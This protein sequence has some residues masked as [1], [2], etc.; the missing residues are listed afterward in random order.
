MTKTSMNDELMEQAVYGGAILGGGGGGWIKDGLQKGKLALEIGEVSLTTID[1]LDVK[2]HVACVALVG[3]P[4]AKNQYVNAKQLYSTVNLLQRNYHSSISALMTNENG[5]STTVNGWIQSA[6]TGL[7][8]LDAPCNGRAHPTGSMGA[9]NLSEVEDYVSY[10]AAAGGKAEYEISGYVKGCLDYTSNVIRQM[11]VEA[12]GMVG[13]ARNPVK[14]DYIQKHAAVGG[15]SQAISVGE[16]F[17]KEENPLNK[18]EAVATVLQGRV[19]KVG[20][21]H[22]YSL[23]TKGGF[24]VGELY[25]D[26]LQ[27]TFWNEYMTAE[28]N[29]ERKG[30]FPDLLMTF[31]AETGIPLVSAE[32]QDGAKIAVISVPKE[33][34]LLSST[35]S[36]NVLL[37]KIQS[38]INKRV[39]F[40]EVKG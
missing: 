4:A 25:V 35:M 36:N 17:L 11:S 16:V 2:D 13:V 28:E 27:L 3:A 21:V 15:I 10:Q 5:A 40:D 30:T 26:D 12:G 22:H 9:L 14:V 6:L 1:E 37:E 34:L 20:K 23:I 31:D 33:Q 8:V 39:V 7:P 18:V 24:D 38:V 32:I 19:I 29:G